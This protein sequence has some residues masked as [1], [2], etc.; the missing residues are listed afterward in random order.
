[1]TA[2]VL[3]QPKGWGI[4]NNAKS[5][6]AV[7]HSNG[8]STRPADRVVYATPVTTGGNVTDGSDE[9]TFSDRSDRRGDVRVDLE[10]LG[11]AG[12]AED[13]QQSFLRA[14]Q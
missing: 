7:G 10:N 3:P 2:P 1:M 8:S 11:Q 5:P 6:G 12:D 14:D 4:R 13:L 9:D